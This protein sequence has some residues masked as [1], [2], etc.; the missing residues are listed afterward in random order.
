MEEK[1]AFI[2]GLNEA[3]GWAEICIPEFELQHS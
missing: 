2:K 1:L 3:V